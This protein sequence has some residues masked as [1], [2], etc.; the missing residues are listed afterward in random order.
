MTETGLG[1]LNY[2]P[3]TMQIKED[4][5]LQ[6]ALLIKRLDSLDKAT[7][8]HNNIFLMIAVLPPLNP[9]NLANIIE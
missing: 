2:A 9:Q 5:F 4:R 8:I 6:L 7:R 3:L 1:I